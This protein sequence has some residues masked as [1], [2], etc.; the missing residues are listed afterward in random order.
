M[1]LS[2]LSHPLTALK[3]ADHG[4]EA[5]LR[6][7]LEGA[8]FVAFHLCAEEPKA[9]ALFHAH[10]RELGMLRIR[11]LRAPQPEG[12]AACAL[13]TLG[14]DAKPFLE[15]TNEGRSVLIAQIQRDLEHRSLGS[16]GD[17]S[18]ASGDSLA[19]HVTREVLVDV[20]RDPVN[21]TAVFFFKLHGLSILEGD[22]FHVQSLLSAPSNFLIYWEQRYSP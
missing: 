1:G 13:P 5:L 2:N 4:L 11:A 12:R 20:T 15:S 3:I 10:R 14:C 17:L 22:E 7:S 6:G 8:G 18:H 16:A 19:A 21:A 9:R